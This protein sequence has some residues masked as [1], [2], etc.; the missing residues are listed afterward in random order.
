MFKLVTRSSNH[1]L[2]KMSPP[3]KDT[4]Q[5]NDNGAKTMKNEYYRSNLSGYEVRVSVDSISIVGDFNS[6]FGHIYPH[7][8]GTRECAYGM[9]WG[10]GLS[11]R[12][13]AFIK[14]SITK[15]D[16]RNLL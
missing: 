12:V 10:F 8:V 14:E 5:T 15:L 2:I 1:L 11:N 4:E 3:R 7:L 6:N 13:K 9:D 16:A